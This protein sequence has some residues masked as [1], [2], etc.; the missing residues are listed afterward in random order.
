MCVGSFWRFCKDL[1]LFDDL[2]RCSYKV[3]YVSKPTACRSSFLSYATSFFLWLGSNWRCICNHSNLREQS[4]GLIFA[5]P[6]HSCRIWL[7][8]RPYSRCVFLR[9][10]LL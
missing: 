5:V 10:S 2:R 3:R 1:S 8:S 6:P 4:H 7:G 9:S